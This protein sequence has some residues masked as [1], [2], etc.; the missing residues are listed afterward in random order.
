M[1]A[2]VL[3]CLVACV[4]GMTINPMRRVVN[5]L[6]KTQAKLIQEGRD[7]D[8]A[9]EKYAC[10]CKN[11]V[12]KIAAQI[13]D[14]SEAGK[15]AA[16]AAA[17]NKARSEQLKNDVAQ[18]KAA[19]AD[20]KSAIQQATAMHNKEKASY[21]ET[22][23][24]LKEDLG[25]LGQ[26][27]AALE[28]GM[29][30]SFMQSRTQVSRLKRAIDVSVNISD[31]DREVLM[32]YMQNPFGDYSAQSGEILGIL[33]EMGGQ[34]KADLDKN[35]S[36]LATAVA[37]FKEL[38]ATKQNEIAELTKSIEQKSVKMGEIAVQAVEDSNAAAGAEAEVKAN[39]EFLADLDGNC[40]KEV[41]L[42]NEAKA[43]RAEEL[44]GLG[45]AIAVLNDD[46]ALEI[47]KKTLPTPSAFVQTG[48]KID[49]RLQAVAVIRETAKYSKVPARLNLLA[50]ALQTG[51]VDFSKVLK[52]IDEMV[53]HLDQEQ[54]GDN[55]QLKYCNSELEKNADRM[56]DMGRTAKG[57]TAQIDDLD[58][59]MADLSEKMATLEADIKEND[60]AAEEATKLR[61]EENEQWTADKI[62]LNSGIMLVEKATGI[63]ACTYELPT[64][65]KAPE[66]Q[67][68]EEQRIA[69]N[70]G[71]EI[72]TAAPELIPGTNI[73]VIQKVD[74]GKEPESAGEYKKDSSTATGVMSLMEM[75]VKDLKKQI[76]E[77]DF[78]EKTAQE[79]YEENMAALKK[80]N[81]ANRKSLLGAQD[82]HAKASEDKSTAESEKKS[83]ADE[84]EST[85][86]VIASLHGECDFLIN[87][88]DARKAARA[89]ER[90][91][92][93]QGKAILSGANFGF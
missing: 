65:P 53:A 4:A 20:A 58:A 68:T 15:R 82:A 77:G 93:K 3:I 29:G 60:K 61:K 73:A 27:I 10:Y 85:Q 16:A 84:M 88:F 31:E 14:D 30:K 42:Y 81:N 69:Q 80:A 7:A 41:K 21:E 33:K 67:L 57:L 19:R 86:G 49:S 37:N 52:M 70:L 90:E 17:E 23:A 72:P 66:R 91:G 79:D 39:R 11:G 78:E 44:E 26:A 89:Q 18:A 74:I 92:L 13:S 87:N 9:Y 38:I 51:K 43:T 28:K 1:R 64:C 25:A 46:D 36:E 24:S 71:E 2:A 56:K 83:N 34:Q 55:D 5:I 75:A 8:D 6:Q 63:L 48:M 47:F 35:E 32:Q 62:Q 76:Q 40:K 12:S 22:I 54:K 50:Y 45:K 59:Q